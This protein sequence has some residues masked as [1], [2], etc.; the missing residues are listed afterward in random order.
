[1]FGEDPAAPLSV[2]AVAARADVSVGSLRYHFP[3]Q[4]ALK[5][6]VM[7]VVYDTVASDDPI[8]DRS[9]PAGE[10]LL[11][12]LRQVLAPMGTGADAR[13]AFETLV[14]TFIDP[15]PS[16]EVEESYRAMME[17]GRL[18]V[19]HWLSVLAEEGYLAESEVAASARLL[20]TVLDGL[21]LR[22]ALPGTGDILAAE[23]QVLRHAVESAL[24]PNAWG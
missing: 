19:E 5:S 9:L 17:S 23:T 4:F 1:M 13:K 11:A 15:E 24:G 3:T 18:R 16:A 22:R 2:R 6:E 8:H 14:R 7:K 20:N 10:R 12:C 21:S